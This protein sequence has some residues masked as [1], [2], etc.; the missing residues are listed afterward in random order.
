MDINLSELQVVD[1]AAK[2]RFEVH[3]AGETAF[4]DYARGGDTITYLHME[5][6]KSL[7][8]HGIAGV[9]AQYALD[10]ARAGHLQVIPVCPY[11]REYIRSGR[12]KHA[13]Q[14]KQ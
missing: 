6:P 5:V 9:L 7:E 11:V 14:P 8:G 13:A 1:D 4:L 10:Y 12:D 2:H 3:V